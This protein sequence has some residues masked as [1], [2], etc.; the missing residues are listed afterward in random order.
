MVAQSLY[1]H[2]ELHGKSTSD[3]HEMIHQA[4]KN[5][6][7][8]YTDGE[9]NGRLI[10]KEEYMSELDKD[11]LDKAFSNTFA[12]GKNDIKDRPPIVTRTRWVSKGAWKFTENKDKLLDMIPQYPV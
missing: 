1:S 12:E 3:K 8:D 4:G 10:V 7:T 2:K 6:A 9:K 11:T 5:W